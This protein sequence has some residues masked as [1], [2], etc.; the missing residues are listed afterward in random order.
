[1]EEEQI[2]QAIVYY[3]SGSVDFNEQALP[4]GEPG[5]VPESD[6]GNIKYATRSGFAGSDIDLFLYGMTD[7]DAF[8]RVKEISDVLTRN[9]GVSRIVRTA[10][11]ITF[12]R[13]WPFRHVQVI[14][15]IYDSPA[16]AVLCSFDVDCWT[17]STLDASPLASVPN[18]SS[19]AAAAGAT[20]HRIR[21]WQTV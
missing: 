15:R 21:P 7:A 20:A 17:D 2:L 11:A 6:D 10:H 8:D 9:G 14:L 12:K 13:V 16:D 1:M 18:A 3:N 4:D 19:V 5:M